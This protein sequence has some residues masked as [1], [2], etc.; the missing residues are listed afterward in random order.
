MAK[1]EASS[2]SCRPGVIS[3]S[4]QGPAPP[5][6]PAV[7]GLLVPTHILRADR[8]TRCGGHGLCRFFGVKKAHPALLLSLPAGAE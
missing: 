2:D 8:F 3:L 6:F 1:R 7:P 4:A 5:D